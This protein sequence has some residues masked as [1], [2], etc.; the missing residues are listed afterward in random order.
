[1]EAAL[2]FYVE[3]LGF[4]MTQK[5]VVDGKVRWCRL[6]HGGAAM[7]LQEFP[8]EGHD[9]WV[10][11]CKVGEGVSVCFICQDAL[12][13]YRAFRS[14][15]VDASTP[16]VGNGMWVTSLTDPD[17]YRIDFESDTDAEEESVYEEGS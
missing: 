5:W 14:R 10:P 1:M 17:G 12:A 6:E 13:L 4:E 9:S 7:M 8:R 3:G 11:E 15:G 16:M 2:R